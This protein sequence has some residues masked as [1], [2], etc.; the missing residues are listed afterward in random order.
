MNIIDSNTNENGNINGENTDIA[1]NNAYLQVLRLGIEGISPDFD[2]D[3]FEYFVLVNDSVD[4]F[5]LTAIAENPNAK[6]NIKGNKDFKKGINKVEIEV[7]SKDGT[8]KNTYIINVSKTNDVI[9]ANSNLETLAIEYSSLEPPFDPNNTQYKASVSNDVK[10]L[11]VL[12]IPENV[13]AKVDITGNKDLQYG[14]NI[15]NVVVTA[16]NGFTIKRYVIKV[17]RKT[18]EE[19]LRNEQ[20]NKENFERL[21]TLLEAEEYVDENENSLENIKNNRTNRY[22]IPVIIVIVTAGIITVYIM[23]KKKKGKLK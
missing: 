13:N 11:N 6:V 7:I 22:I 5:D 14:S 19:E 20:E 15:V 12:A 2:K 4:K 9:K 10:N 18:I 21:S 17:Y 23:I 8:N 1:D 16:E 3:V